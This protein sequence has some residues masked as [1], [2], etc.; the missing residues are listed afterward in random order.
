MTKYRFVG[1]LALTTACLLQLAAAQYQPNPLPRHFP[2]KE[3]FVVE[4]ASTG[5]LTYHN[6]PVIPTAFVVPIYWGPT[7]GNGGSDSAMSTSLTNY[8]DGNGSTIPG[9]GE[10]HEYNVIT[11]YYQTGPT[12]ITLS[13]LGLNQGA[14]YDNSTPPTNVTDA[15]VQ[16]EVL[17]MTGNSPRTDTI[18]EVFL[19]ASSYSS[20][21]TSTSCG[22]N[23]LQYCAYHGN[24]SY[25]SFNVKYA[26]MP[27]PSCGGC[28]T[29]GWSNSQNF[30][31]FISHETREAVTDPDG[32]GWDDRRGYEA[33]DKCA[34][35]PTPFTDSS[36]GTNQDGTAFAY[37]YEWSNATGNCVKTK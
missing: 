1:A 26:S 35:S 32:T 9:Y 36:T 22:G 7:W 34:W 27:Y 28:Q 23:N 13:H 10:T 12:Y 25:G 20:N 30:E 15:A 16:A 2:T 33:D 3:R 19:P 24:F 8:I 14:L 21:G 17:K 6:G 4:M 37:Q 29:S 11:Q 5:N 31:H 18:Y